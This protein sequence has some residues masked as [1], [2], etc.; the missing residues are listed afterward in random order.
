LVAVIIPT[1][2]MSFVLPLIVT[3]PPPTVRIPV[4]LASPFTTRA[5]NPAPGVPIV[6][7]AETNAW[8]KYPS[9]HSVVAAPTLKV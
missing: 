4:I 1:P 2:L 7:P 9:L 3:D 8:V 5:V 6:A